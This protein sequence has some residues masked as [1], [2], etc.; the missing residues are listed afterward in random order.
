M[1]RSIVQLFLGRD[2]SSD[3]VER[4]EL[5]IS[6]STQLT[7]LHMYLHC[8]VNLVIRG[9]GRFVMLSSC[10]TVRGKAASFLC[11]IE[12][13]FHESI[14]FLSSEDFKF[15]L[16]VAFSF[17]SNLVSIYKY[18]T[19]VKQMCDLV[20]QSISRL[21]YPDLLQLYP[22]LWAWFDKRMDRRRRSAA[23]LQVSSDHVPRY[24]LMDPIDIHQ[25]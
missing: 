17:L 21:V 22:F 19:F 2:C 23:F 1:L 6:A 18:L 12:H 5:S 15:L 16:Y 7:A 9:T 8:S 4:E 13:Q 10:D 3:F 24:G 14:A 25:D 11:A 20:S